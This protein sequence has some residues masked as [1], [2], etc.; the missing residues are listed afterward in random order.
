[1]SKS[2]KILKA[3]LGLF[4][5]NGFHGT[6]TSKIAKEAGVANGTL[7][8]YFKTKEELINEL[9]LFIKKNLRHYQLE[10][11]I[12]SQS[13]YEKVKHVWY[14]TV[15]WGIEN[16]QEYIFHQQFHSSPYINSISR[17]Q[18]ALSFQ[19][20]RDI[21]QEGI[22]NESIINEDVEFINGYVSASSFA[23]ITYAIKHPQ[24]VTDKL[25]ERGFKMAWHSIVNF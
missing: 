21:L 16:P 18:G 20:L 7:F 11:Y 25:I 1:M 4:I 22:D 14:Q 15:K 8:H 17:K 6:P 10:N 24:K 5:E 12:E 19:H 23:F 13:T 9:Y 2:E 3:A